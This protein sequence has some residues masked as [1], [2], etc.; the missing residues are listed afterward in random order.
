MQITIR[1]HEFRILTEARLE[2][3]Q[4]MTGGKRREAYLL[5]EEI[6]ALEQH[7]EWPAFRTRCRSALSEYS[8]H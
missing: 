7:T 2:L 8:V 3:Q 4:A 5:L 6:R 1:E